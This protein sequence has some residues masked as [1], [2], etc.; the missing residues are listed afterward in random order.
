MNYVELKAQIQAYAENYGDDFLASID[1]II[2][3]A[4][5]R[6]Y[7]D[8]R[9]PVSRLTTVVPVDTGTASLPAD[10]IEV[11]EVQYVGG[12]LLIQ[13]EPSFLVEAY[14]L[15]TG[16]PEYYAYQDETTLMFA[17]QPTSGSVSVAYFGYPQSIVTA[18]TT[19][20]SE[21]YDHAL[22]SA[23][24]FESAVFMKAESDMVAIYKAQYDTA[25]ASLKA[26]T[27]GDK[28]RTG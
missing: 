23:C 1:T 16:T 13:K 15:S 28:F 7:N 14:G 11:Q 3:Q 6:I 25:L 22:L 21:N 27:K 4:E 17:P 9:L 26:L 8:A 24:L 10:F 5:R 2:G 18:G 19:W 12:A 20:L